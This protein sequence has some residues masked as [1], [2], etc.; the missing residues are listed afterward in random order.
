[1]NFNILIVGKVQKRKTKDERK[2]KKNQPSIIYTDSV[3][4]VFT[5]LQILLKF[6][7]FCVIIPNN[8]SEIYVK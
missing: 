1:M 2:D 6:C 8:R 5:F 4:L 3:T 7:W